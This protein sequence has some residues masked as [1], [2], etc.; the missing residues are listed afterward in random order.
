M[1]RL[2]LRLPVLLMAI[3]FFNIIAF[4]DDSIKEGSWKISS[5]SNSQEQV[6]GSPQGSVDTGSMQYNGQS[7]IAT[8]QGSNNETVCVTKNTV[9]NLRK[10]PGCPEPQF[11]RNGSTVDY[12]L[13]CDMSGV[14]VT[15]NGHYEFKGEVMDGSVKVVTG[16]RMTTEARVTGKYLGPCTQDGT[17]NQNLNS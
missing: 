1:K 9:E 10:I 6:P 5:T 17:N 13:S 16:N 4:A 11:I 8:M 3:A 14:P 2:I 12:S 7:G 15:I